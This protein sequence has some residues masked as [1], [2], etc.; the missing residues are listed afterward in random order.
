MFCLTQSNVQLDWHPGH[1]AWPPS[2]DC[3][4]QAVRRCLQGAPSAFSLCPLNFH[5]EV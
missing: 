5:Q 2:D 3:F 1:G 4:L